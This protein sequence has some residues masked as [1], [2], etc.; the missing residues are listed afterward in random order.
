MGKKDIQIKL[1]I[2]LADKIGMKIKE[3]GFNTITEYVVYVLEQTLSSE[4]S[5]SDEV[6]SEEEEKN[7]RERLKELGYL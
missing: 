1:P 6:Y 2:K 4:D 5:S 7:I 3:A